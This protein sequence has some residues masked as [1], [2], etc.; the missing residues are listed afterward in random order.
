MFVR[1]T[2]RARDEI[3]KPAWPGNVKRGTRNL[4]R[5]S[6]NKRDANKWIGFS[7]DANALRTTRS[8]LD[9][10]FAR[11]VITSRNMRR[12]SRKKLTLL[13]SAWFHCTGTSR[14][15]KPA[16]CAK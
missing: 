3:G 12:L 1:T 10:D 16:R 13:P 7:E 15:R 6:R 14:I 4:V 11:T 8:T 2:G 9:H 5:V